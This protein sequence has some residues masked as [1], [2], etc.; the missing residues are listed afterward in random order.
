M[1][2]AFVS[3]AGEQ[4]GD[5]GKGQG[6]SDMETSGELKVVLV[7]KPT[8]SFWESVQDITRVS[9]YNCVEAMGCCWVW[10]RGNDI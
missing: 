8:A 1:C 7:G 2:Q 5:S 4:L 3:K 9:R 10:T 6:R